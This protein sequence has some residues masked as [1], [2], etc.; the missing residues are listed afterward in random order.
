MTLAVIGLA[1]AGCT[2]SDDAEPDASPTSPS[3]ASSSAAPAVT[4]R[5][6]WGKGAGALPRT[7]RP[8][9]V[10]DVQAVVDGWFDAAYLSGDYPRSSFVGSWKGFTPGAQAQA[11]RDGDLMSNRDIGADITGVTPVSRAV[12]LDVLSVRKRPVGVTARVDLRFATTGTTAQR[13]HV[14][15]QLYL[16]NGKQG[17]QVFGYDVRK[18]AQ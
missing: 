15:G 10:E 2:G 8:R 13:V 6:S 18:A 3:A 11:R 16:T 5:V 17:W 4:T 12:T 1:T 7:L 14:A 9:L